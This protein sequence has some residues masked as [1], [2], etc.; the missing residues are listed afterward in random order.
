MTVGKF[1]GPAF[2]LRRLILPRLRDMIISHERDSHLVSVDA[3]LTPFATSPLRT[4]ADFPFRG[5]L[6]GDLC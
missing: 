3:V 6:Q 1:R 2:R 4:P 5:A